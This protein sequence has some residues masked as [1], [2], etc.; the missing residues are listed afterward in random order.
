MSTTVIGVLTGE[1]KTRVDRGHRLVLQ[2]VGCH[3]SRR[4][5]HLPAVLRKPSD[6]SVTTAMDPRAIESP[7]AAARNPRRET[8][9]AVHERPVVVVLLVIV[10]CVVI[11]KC[12]EA[13]GAIE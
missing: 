1:P 5:A 7:S 12:C 3:G 4:V 6:I 2:V 8:A 13:D 9:G 10:A 11:W